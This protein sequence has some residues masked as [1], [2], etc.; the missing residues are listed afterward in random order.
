MYYSTFSFQLHCLKVVQ[1][2]VGCFVMRYEVTVY[3][4]FKTVFRYS[5]IFSLYLDIKIM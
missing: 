2:F 1:T 3:D 5:V 4:Y